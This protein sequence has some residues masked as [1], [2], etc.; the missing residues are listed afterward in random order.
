[1][2]YPL[3][4]LSRTSAF[5]AFSTPPKKPRE[6][7]KSEATGSVSQSDFDALERL[8][9][10]EKL[11]KILNG[12]WDEPT[13]SIFD[14]S[15]LPK[16][17]LFDCVRDF[18]MACKYMRDGKSPMPIRVF[19]CLQAAG[20]Q[21]ETYILTEKYQ[22]YA[23]VFISHFTDFIDDLD[24]IESRKKRN[25]M[26]ALINRLLTSNQKDRG[27]LTTQI[28]D[29]ETNID[30]T[31]YAQDSARLLQLFER[32]QPRKHPSLLKKSCVCFLDLQREQIKHK[33]REVTFPNLFPP[34]PL[35]KR[36]EFLVVRGDEAPL[37]L[38]F[39]DSYAS[40]LETHITYLS[41][42]TR[43]FSKVL[44]AIE[45]YPGPYPHLEN[46]TTKSAADAKKEK[47]KIIAEA[48]ERLEKLFPRPETPP[49][50]EAVE[51]ANE[52]L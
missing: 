8:S 37:L 52:D 46:P 18:G 5:S 44:G 51:A 12:F 38:K 43:F 40:F 49:T 20:I 36:E 26:Y 23:A 19:I 22:K 33:A 9:D 13:Q 10:R 4:A 35:T 39:Y 15:K 48:N 50:Q 3:G 30:I 29:I 17:E 14:C 11:S 41:K 31:G 2:V 32:C 47:L 7:N 6:E 45:S 16:H 28:K 24:A 27:L 21:K 42:I 1:M 25:Y 34:L